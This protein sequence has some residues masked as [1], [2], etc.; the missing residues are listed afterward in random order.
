MSKLYLVAFNA[1]SALG[2]A[3]VLFLTLTNHSTSVTLDVAATNDFSKTL[4]SW[5]APYVAPSYSASWSVVAPVQ[6][7]AALEVLHVLFRLVRSPLPT[8]LMQVSSRL[9]L[10]WAIVAR[11]PSTHL[12]PFYTTMVFAWSL[13]EVL[14]YTYYALSLMGAQV[15]PVLTWL[16]YTTFYVLYPLGAGSEALVTLSTIPEWK[17]GQFL[18]WNIEAWVKAGMVLIWIPGMSYILE[19]ALCSS[20]CQAYGS[21]IPT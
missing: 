5:V 21:C 7:L 9:I 11:F 16:R 14:R 4:V 17:N 20:L 3:A 1:A 18:S 2:W 10:V 6:S 12:N 13:T 19:S 15:P 8:T